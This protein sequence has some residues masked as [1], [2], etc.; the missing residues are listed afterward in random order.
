[1]LVELLQVAHGTPGFHERE[2]E[3]HSLSWWVYFDEKL[4]QN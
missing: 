3:Y 4:E 1:M 2:F